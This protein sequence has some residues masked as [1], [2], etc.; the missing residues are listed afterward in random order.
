MQLISDT[1]ILASELATEELGVKLAVVT[2]HG[3]TWL[4]RGELGSGKTTLTRGLVTGLGGDPDDVASPT[5][6]VI[7]RYRCNT[8]WIYHLDLYRLDESGVWSIG[9]EELVR[10]TDYLVVEWSVAH[11]PWPT[12]WVGNLTFDINDDQRSAC[13]NYPAVV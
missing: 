9:L 11:G 5:Y 4:L 12:K 1:C 10:P 2:P 7:H 3:G 6:S 8:C 13:W